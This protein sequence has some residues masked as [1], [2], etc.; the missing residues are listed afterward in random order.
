M[1]EELQQLME[2]IRTDGVE[3]ADAEAREIVENAREQAKAIIEEAERDAAAKTEQAERDADAFAQRGA[4]SLRQAAR[5]VL[6]SL[7]QAIQQTMEAVVA[8]N[9]RDAM[10]PERV[11]ELV[12]RVVTAY[13]DGLPGEARLDVLLSEDDREQLSNEFLN[14]F[15]ANVKAGVE[16]KGDRTVISGFRVAL[17]DQ[18][19]EHD[20][21]GNAVT[22]ALCGLLRPKLA[23]IVR[24]A[25]EDTDGSGNNNDT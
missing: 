4:T 20:F 6:L 13:A 24:S 9:A 12:Q 19:V 2:R 1:P 22:E 18:K 21:S 3:R 17:S 11:A 10:T 16:I 7:E 14:T 25:T 15:A 8:Q 23:E 5:N